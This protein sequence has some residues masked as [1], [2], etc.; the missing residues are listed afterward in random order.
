M[1]HPYAALGSEYAAL[2]ARASIT[3]RRPVQLGIERVMD[4]LPRYL[5]LSAPAV[6]IG[7][8]DLRESDCN[9]HLGLGQGDPWDQVSRHVPANKGPFASW[10]AAAV[11]YIAYDHLD[12]PPAPWCWEVACY[13]GENWNGWGP[14]LHGC[15]TGYLW[16]CTSV[17]DPVRFGGQGRGGKYVRDGVWDPEEIDAQPGIIPVMQGVIALRPDL[18]LPRA[19]A[20]V[21]APTMVPA[22]RPGPEGTGQT[23]DGARWLQDALNRVLD[24]DPPLALDG[25]VGR[26]TTQA[27]RAFQQAYGLRVDGLAGNTETLPR[28][29]EVLASGA[30]PAAASP[31]AGGSSAAAPQPRRMRVVA[32]SG[33]NVRQRPS[34]TSVVVRALPHGAVVVAA[35]HQDGPWIQVGD[36]AAPF[37]WVVAQYLEPIANG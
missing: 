28:L 26:R 36:V 20:T 14:R 32:P 10:R 3:R 27:V 5:D 21:Q 11:F 1:Q 16:S 4:S 24:F 34:S 25:S 2:L 35:Q 13:T 6:L 8:L 17:Y 9:P 29:R 33:L 15:H 23:P 7:A 12:A 19:Y 30:P 18:A 22:P 37:G 31:A